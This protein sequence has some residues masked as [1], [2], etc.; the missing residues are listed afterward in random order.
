M[1]RQIIIPA[2]LAAFAALAVPAV[3]GARV[4]EYGVAIRATNVN[5][6]HSVT[7]AWNLES[8][9]V[10]NAWIAVDGAIVRSGSDRGTVFT[11]RPLPGGSHTITV[12]AREVFETYTSLGSACVVSAGHY[13][14]VR[15]WRSSTSVSVPYEK[16]CVVPRIVGLRLAVA[17]ARISSAGCSLGGLERVHSERLPGTV[18][19]QRPSETRNELRDG[20][21]IRLVVSLGPP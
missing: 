11:T 21:P 9:N 16:H 19:T 14:C 13:V 18:L 17:R 2:A 3:A 5:A 6:D 10:A 1:K 12:Q 8:A 15:D 7:I 20:A 4:D